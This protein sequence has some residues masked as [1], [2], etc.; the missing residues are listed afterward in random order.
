M[1]A[2]G[3]ARG[4]RVLW[5]GG[6]PAA[7]FLGL[8]VVLGL[9]GC[10]SRCLCA[11]DTSITPCDTLHGRLDACQAQGQAFTFEGVE[12][13][14]LHLKVSS[15]VKCREAPDLCLQ[16]PSGQIVPL[17]SH[18]VRCGKSNVA[19]RDLV[20]R[21]TGTYIATVLPTHDCGPNYY[22]ANYTLR[23]PSVENYR[24]TLTPCGTQPIYVMAPRG[25][26]VT[27]A[28]APVCGDVRPEIRSVLDP[29]GGRALDPCRLLPN[30][31]PAQI[32][33][34]DDGTVWLNFNAPVPGRYTIETAAKG[35]CSGV[36]Q[37][38]AKVAPTGGC[39]RAVLH[40]DRCPTD[41]GMAG[42][43]VAPAPAATFTSWQPR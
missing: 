17:G 13:S 5:W 8:L 15:D 2:Y 28:V 4:G 11:T 40:P 30:A 22:R 9:S 34:G 7:V 31:P 24:V 12:Y 27:V 43:A 21:E 14:I 26:Q 38:T 6:R 41:Y 20:L 36:V 33:H 23:F 32:D 16:S 35:P 10:R 39:P 3:S 25:G 42:G 29:W 19:I 37:V 1:G 18:V